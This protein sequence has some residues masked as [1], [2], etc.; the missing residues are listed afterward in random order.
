MVRELAGGEVLHRY[1]EKDPGWFRPP[2]QGKCRAPSTAT[3]CAASMW[4]DNLSQFLRGEVEH[5]PFPH[6][7]VENAFDRYEELRAAMPQWQEIAPLRW[8]PN[9]RY[10]L[11]AH[12]LTDI[13]L[14]FAISATAPSFW[15]QIQ[16][17]FGLKLK[18]RVGVRGLSSSPILMDCNVGCNTPGLGR[19]RGPHT[20]NPKEIWAGLWYFGEGGGGAL[21]LCKAIAPIRRWGKDEI[22][23]DCVEVVKTIPY[24]H[25]TFVCF[26]AKDAIH[27]VT[28]RTVIAPRYLVNLLAEYR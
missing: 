27:A 18:D 9:H 4:F 25:N 16:A 20:D 7:V 21:Q 14:H 5:D 12:Q 11:H 22:E 1:L 15:A 26:L 6:L 10:D 23:D 13:W 3:S 2:F 8:K 24:R 19:V 28:P 17:K